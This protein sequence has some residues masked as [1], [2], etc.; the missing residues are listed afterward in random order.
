MSPDLPAP[1]RDFYLERVPHQWNDCLD[2][3]ERAGRG[4]DGE[5]RRIFE[6]MRVVN[7]SLGVIILGDPEE[8][9]HLNVEKGRMSPSQEPSH[10]PL[11]T[12]IHDRDATLAFARTSGDSILGFLGGLAG[13]D[14]ALRLTSQRVENLSLLRGTLRFELRGEDGFALTAHFGPPPPGGEPD[15]TLVM[16]TG[17]YRALQTGELEA[18]D[19]FMGGDVEILGDTELGIQ[20]ALAVLAPD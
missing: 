7:T 4:E 5:A 9:I 16:D 15:C 1:W 11:L 10:A 6:A 18:Q 2:A 12:L 8:H 20:L 17:T 3:Q 19:A 14:A 13:L